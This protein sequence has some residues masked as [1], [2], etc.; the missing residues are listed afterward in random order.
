[1]P[2]SLCLNLAEQE[3]FRLLDIARRSIRSGLESGRA[4][5]LDTEQL[6]KS[7]R[8]E[9]AVFVTL[10]RLGELR[11]C[12]GSLQPT[13]TLA[14]AVAN[15]AF[16]AAFRDRRFNRLQSAEVD[17]LCI[18]VSILSEMVP[19]EVTDRQ[20]LLD[21]LQPG[22]DGLLLE[23][24]GYRSTFLP[25]VWEKIKSPNEFLEQ[26]MLKAGLPAG[27][28]SGTIKFY[29]YHTLTFAEK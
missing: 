11:G 10:T 4:V 8:I 3:Q 21:T 28:W 12:I 29:R 15:S 9:A 20:D 16:S 25:K 13:D 18:E 5:Q 14:Q 17:E 23:D 22:L 6:D 7:L 19:I 27:H 2:P 1:M 24:R 26:L